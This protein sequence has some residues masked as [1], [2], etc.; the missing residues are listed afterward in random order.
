VNP[1][2]VSGHVS[3]CP[4]GHTL[5]LRGGVGQP[6]RRFLDASSA[7][8]ERPEELQHFLDAVVVPALLERW[9]VEHAR[10]QVA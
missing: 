2:T 1:D 10:P 5:P 6:V 3:G 8:A 4:D 9:R 7:R